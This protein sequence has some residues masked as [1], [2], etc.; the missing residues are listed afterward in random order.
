M[1]TLGRRGAPRLCGGCPCPAGQDLARPPRRPGSLM[2]RR[3]QRT[4]VACGLHPESA[5]A[6]SASAAAS[7]RAEGPIP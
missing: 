6:G 5:P 7:C 4:Q 3:S 2:S 1:L